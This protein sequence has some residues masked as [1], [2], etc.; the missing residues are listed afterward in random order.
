MA[1]DQ[2]NNFGKSTVTT[3]YSNSATSIIVTDGS[4]FPD[5]ASGNYNVVWWNS[6]DY[7][8]PSDDPNREV[9]RVT[10]KSTNTLTVTRAQE[11]TSATSKNSVGK[12]YTMILAPTAKMITDIGTSLDTKVV[13]PGSAT[14]NAIARF[15]LTTGKLVQN[16]AVTI[17]DTGVVAGASI[18]GSTN[19]ITNVPIAT[20][21]SGLGA[22]VATF[23][24]T[25]SSANLAAALTDE[26]GTGA[27]VF[28]NSPTLVTPAL[29]TPSSATL[30]N[31]TGLPLATGVT[32]QLALA[33][34]GTGANLVDPNADRLMFWDDSA[35]NVDWLTLGTNLS[36]TGT[37]LNAS[38]GGS[39]D[40]VGPGSAT[41]NAIAR[42]DSTTG[43]L[44]QNSAVTVDDTG[45]IAGSS[46]SGSTNTITNVSLA[47]GVTGNLPVTNLNSGTSAS[48]TTFWRGDGTWATPAGGGGGTPGGSNTQVQYNNAG[49]FGGI[50]GATTDGT[51]LTLVAPVLG[52]PA[53]GT[54][55][56]TT[57]LPI[58]TGV[59]GLGAGIA[60]FLATPSSAN[61]ATAVTDETGSGALV[62]ATAP[63]LV[64]PVLGVATAT[65]INKVA[66]TAPATSATLTLADG[67]TLATS[68]AN[69][70]TLTS[71]GATN[72]TL[73]TT[74]TLATLAGTETF[75]NKRVTKRVTSITSNAT[76]TVN[77]DNCDCVDIT[78]LAAAITSMTTNL[79]GTPT[80]FQSLIYRIKDNG[81]ARAITWGASFAA[82][83]VALPTTT[84]ISKL[85]TVGFIWNGSVWGCV[86]SA[87]EA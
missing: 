23:L 11:S 85:L 83:G 48:A 56:N 18:S 36:I 87:Q 62:F 33:N 7:F 63:T 71:S 45:V 32:G 8:D 41:D 42:F 81:T 24:A 64:T 6:T 1:L 66:L 26:T 59:S 47:T 9:V 60:T 77:T 10:A 35:G 39:G 74:G 13:G 17:D 52:T 30:T 44:I 37:T 16:S 15:D 34:G 84:V 58:S 53:S 86:A 31:A 82:N 3:G 72:V 50:T 12:E 29:G 22:N 20:G 40:V 46:I 5:P 55:T 75:T 43:K 2:V 28:A 38:G 78:A 51:T 21:I 76:P 49:A 73:P 69:S 67:S 65:S 14:D 79:S 25:P 54:L 19:T 27:N 80:N 61:L 70:I 68:G 4:R 57:G